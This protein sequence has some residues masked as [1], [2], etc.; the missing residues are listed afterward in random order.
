AQVDTKS[1]AHARDAVM[2]SYFE[3][4]VDALVYELYFPEELHSQDRYFL[5]LLQREN[6]PV[7]NQAQENQI[8][9]LRQT[10]E[11]LFETNHPIRQ[12]LFF[13]DNVSIIR[14]IE[15]KE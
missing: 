12:N 7:L 8:R 6:L 3:Q 10:F 14:T 15:G 4:I 5:R 9:Q 11:R 13:L 1:S 2:L